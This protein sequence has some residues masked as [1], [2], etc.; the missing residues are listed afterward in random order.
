MGR[1]P[2]SATDLARAMYHTIHDK[3]L[4]LPERRDGDAR[5]RRRVVVR[6]E[7]VGELTSTIGEQRATNPSVQPMTEDDFVE[8]ITH[9]QPAAPSYFTVDAAMNKRV[10]PL[11]DQARTIPALSPDRLSVAECGCGRAQR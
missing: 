3:L 6:Q 2:S 8:L 11:L 1:R 9:G 4:K 5:P 7:P 10:H